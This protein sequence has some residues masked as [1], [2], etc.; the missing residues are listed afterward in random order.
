MKNKD[1]L[2]SKHIIINVHDLEVI[3]YTDEK[4]LSFMIRQVLNN[5]IKYLDKDEKTI[6][7]VIREIGN[8]SDTTGV[9][10]KRKVIMKYFIN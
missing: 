9:N 7:K 1:L 4:W 2:L 8:L 3:V 10:E 5:A 6:K